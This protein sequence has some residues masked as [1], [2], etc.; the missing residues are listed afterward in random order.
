M[1][2]EGFA[3]FYLVI[4]LMIPLMRIIPRLLR[5]RKMK[6]VIQSQT[7]SGG[8]FEQ[9]SDTIQEHTRDPFFV[10]LLTIHASPSLL[11]LN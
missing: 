8:Q 5:R 1:A 10:L 9:N 3:W 11:R 7:F 2:E 6:N 4:F